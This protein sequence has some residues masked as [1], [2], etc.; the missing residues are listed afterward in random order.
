MVVLEGKGAIQARAEG[1][2]GNEGK[3]VAWRS[4]RKEGDEA[5]REGG[6]GKSGLNLGR[7]GAMKAGWRSGGGFVGGRSEAASRD[8]SVVGDEFKK[9]G[10][11]KLVAAP[12]ISNDVFL[13]G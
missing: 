10:M 3:Y 6:G 1:L 4:L 12:G 9:G 5:S 8:C 11:V 13:V 7:G 2:A